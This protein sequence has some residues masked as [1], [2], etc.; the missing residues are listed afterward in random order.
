[1]LESRIEIV[2]VLKMLWKGKCKSH[3]WFH[4]WVIM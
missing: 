3:Q 1:M 2:L 4:M